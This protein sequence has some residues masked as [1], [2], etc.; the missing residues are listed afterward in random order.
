MELENINVNALILAAFTG[1]MVYFMMRY[2]V[3]D[4]K[5]WRIVGLIVSP[6]VSYW[7]YAWKFDSE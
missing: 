5:F 3:P 2:G 4:F 6:L 1:V 7:F